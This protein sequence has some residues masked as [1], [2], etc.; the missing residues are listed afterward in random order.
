MCHAPCKGC[1]ERYA[2]CHSECEK[3]AKYAEKVKKAR[4]KRLEEHL[5]ADEILQVLKRG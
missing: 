2:G 1:T 3:Y 4:E 5:I